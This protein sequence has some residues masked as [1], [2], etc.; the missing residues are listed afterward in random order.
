[1]LKANRAAV[2]ALAASLMLTPCIVRAQETSTPTDPGAV[3]GLQDTVRSLTE[4]LNAQRSE[5]E[6]LQ[7]RL[8]ESEAAAKAAQNDLAARDANLRT[9]QGNQAAAEARTRDLEQQLEAVRAELSAAN[10]A[11]RNELEGLRSQ[12]AESEAAAKAAQGEISA[13]DASIRTAQGAQA[14]AETRA[15]DLEQQL[16]AVRAELSTTKDAQRSLSEQAETVAA[17]AAAQETRLNEVQATLDQQRAELVAAGNDLG[18]AQRALADKDKQIQALTDAGRELVANV[19]ALEADRKSLT[20]QLAAGRGNIETLQRELEGARSELLAA[21]N[22]VGS[23]GRALAEK[24][25]QIASLTTTGRELV[26]RGEEL[27]AANLALEGRLAELAGPGEMFMA[28]LAQSLGPDTP[29]RAEDGRL[30]FPSD[31]A[32]APGASNLTPAAR[33]KALEYGRAIADALATLPSD[34]PWFLRVD[35]HTDRQRVGGRRFATN[36]ELSAARAL[37]VTSVLIEAGVPPERIAPTA[38]GEF[39]PLDPSDTPE[40]YQ[41]NRRIEL[42]LDAD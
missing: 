24:D 3:T 34:S 11:Q 21:R 25:K 7:A 40:A 38:F 10:E 23:A 32:F 6:R 33:A 28:A 19:E 1:M 13:R 31:L 37:M 35:G 12:L 14:A 2:A 27:A 29:L 22:D 30:V 36:R 42:Q 16:D 9:T 20:E 39:R 8:A 4:Q 5:L 17:T 15:R 18:S 26:A 41:A